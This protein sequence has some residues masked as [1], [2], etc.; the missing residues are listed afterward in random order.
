[1]VA[2][3]HT[4]RVGTSTT[5]RSPPPTHTDPVKHQPA[6]DHYGRQG[7]REP[8][9][10]RPALQARRHEHGE[11]EPGDHRD[12]ERGSALA[13]LR[14]HQQGERHDDRLERER[15]GVHAPQTPERV[16]GG[17]AGSLPKRAR[18]SPAVTTDP[19]MTT[20]TPDS[21]PSSASSPACSTAVFSTGSTLTRSAPNTSAASAPSSSGSIARGEELAVTTTSCSTGSSSVRMPRTSFSR[22]TPSTPTTRS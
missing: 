4:L 21:P 12:A 17:H 7:E 11:G 19:V 16:G 3:A 15:G 13:E 10:P 2:T 1:I 20:P 5:P 6:K 14:Q 22:I 18:A 9:L 8:E